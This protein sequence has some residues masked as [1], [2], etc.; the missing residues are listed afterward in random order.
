MDL[1]RVS[2]YLQA[3]VA[4]EDSGMDIFRTWNDWS[5]VAGRADRAV[6]DP[7]GVLF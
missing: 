5:S 1:S 4:L 7:C 2:G 6:L 3:H